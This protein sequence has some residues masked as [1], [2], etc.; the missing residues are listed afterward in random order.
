MSFELADDLKSTNIIVLGI[1]SFYNYRDSGRWGAF[2]LW[3]F[4]SALSVFAS[5][6]LLTV[7]TMK[8]G[9]HGMNDI[10]GLYVCR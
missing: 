4:A 7:Q 5:F 2:V 6:G 10:V 1:I 9:P 3:C 8:D